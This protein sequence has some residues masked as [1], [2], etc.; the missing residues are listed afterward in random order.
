MAELPEKKIVRTNVKWQTLI[1][2]MLLILC[3]ITLSLCRYVVW[4]GKAYQH[5]TELR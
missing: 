4:R 1:P 3:A 5:Q 2:E